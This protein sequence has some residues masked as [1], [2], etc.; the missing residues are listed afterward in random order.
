MF[1]KTALAA[2]LILAV[3]VGGGLRKA[4][5]QDS[6]A[7]KA[8]H[9]EKAVTPNERPERPPVNAYRLDFSIYEI[10]DGKKINTRQYSTILNGDDTGGEIK[11]G[12]RVPAEG[13]QGEFQYLDVGTSITSRMSERGGQLQL[14]VHAE[15]S[16][17]A[18]PEQGQG[19]NSR[20]ILRQLKIGA[21]TLVLL[22]KPMIL[23]SADDPNSKRTFQ[24]EVT[25]TKLR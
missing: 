17:F 6:N 20:P 2:T 3:I 18:L 21:S 4:P 16:N 23:G 9:E 7:G 1:K 24:L 11:I 25:V 5:A 10:E 22:G 12:T 14:F 19:N 8:D 15:I 13:K